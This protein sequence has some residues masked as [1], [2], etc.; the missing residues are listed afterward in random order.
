MVSLDNLNAVKLVAV[1]VPW[2]P[3]VYLWIL[4]ADPEILRA[5]ELV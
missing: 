3:N 1:L 5:G 2:R 4:W